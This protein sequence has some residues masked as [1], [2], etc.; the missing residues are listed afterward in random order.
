PVGDDAPGEGLAA[1]AGERGHEGVGRGGATGWCRGRGAGGQRQRGEGKQRDADVHAAKL[2][3][4]PAAGN[5]RAHAQAP[6]EAPRS[7]AAAGTPSPGRRS[8]LRSSGWTYSASIGST[9]NGIRSTSDGRS[10]LSVVY[11]ISA[12]DSVPGMPK[13]LCRISASTR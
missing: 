3:D 10:V 11:R 2:A 1:V 8:A 6:R 13:R 12:P 4:R 9:S 5:R 7:A